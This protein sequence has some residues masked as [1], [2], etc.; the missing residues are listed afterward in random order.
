MICLLTSKLRCSG[1]SEQSE[2]SLA[3]SITPT[4]P[5]QDYSMHGDPLHLR[6]SKIKTT[7]S[8]FV[9]RICVYSSQKLSIC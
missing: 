1:V 7:S 6:F 8:G 4:T 5:N 9:E 3:H 2:L